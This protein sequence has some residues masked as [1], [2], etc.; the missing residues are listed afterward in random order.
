MISMIV[1]QGNATDSGAII[2]LPEY[3]QRSFPEVYG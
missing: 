2:C 3:L 1:I